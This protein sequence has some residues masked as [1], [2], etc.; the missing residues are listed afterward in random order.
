MN[1]TQPSTNPIGVAI[2]GCGSIALANH[3]PGLAL[4]PR[5]SLVAL[6]DQNEAA[7]AKAKQSVADRFPQWQGV[8]TTTDPADVYSAGD[9]SAVVIATPNA[10]HPPLAKSA[11]AAGKHV[12]CEKPLALSGDDAASMLRAAEAAGVRHMTAFTYRFV[13]AMRYLKHLVDRGDLG[14]PIHFRAQRFQDWGDR[15]LG[16]RQTKALAGT[17]EIGD[18]L[19]HRLDYAHHLVA[20]IASVAATTGRFHQSRGDAMSDVD[21]WVSVLARF[22]GSDASGNLESTKLA[23]GVGEGYGGRDVVELNGEAASALYSTQQPLQLQLSRR[24]EDGYQSIEVPREFHV[25]PGCPRDPGEGDPR[26]TF[27]YDQSYEFIDAIAEDRNCRP[28]FREGVAVQR[29]MDAVV[30]AAEARAWVDVKR[31]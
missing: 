2:V 26:V 23:T 5:A 24:G 13:P 10:S 6:C 1:E 20:P 8:R 21:D 9:V 28:S 16:W 4:H 29:V 11:A 18:M 30:E 3:L 22:D 7:L 12:L 15:P 14:R 27:R 19:S 25:W 31:S 17:G